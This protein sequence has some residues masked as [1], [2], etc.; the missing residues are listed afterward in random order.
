M[1]KCFKFSTVASLVYAGLRKRN[2]ALWHLKRFSG[3]LPVK[4]LNTLNDRQ[5]GISNK[6]D[7]YKNPKGNERI[8]ADELSKRLDVTKL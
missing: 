3:R 5:S 2:H 1:L 6:F 7:L 8:D 4:V